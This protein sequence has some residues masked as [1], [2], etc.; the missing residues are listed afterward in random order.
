MPAS[1]YDYWDF[2]EDD[3]ENL[4]TSSECYVYGMKDKWMDEESAETWAGQ[5]NWDL[6]VI[7]QDGEYLL[8]RKKKV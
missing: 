6:K 5:M 8:S 1:L 2:D 3:Y 4:I 7:N